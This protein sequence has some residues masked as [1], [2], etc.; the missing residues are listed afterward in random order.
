LTRYQWRFRLSRESLFLHRKSFVSNFVFVFLLFV[1]I[2]E[3]TNWRFVL[4]LRFRP[5]V[6]I[7]KRKKN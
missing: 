6:I 2:H 1:F 3:S 5:T 7:I 4:L